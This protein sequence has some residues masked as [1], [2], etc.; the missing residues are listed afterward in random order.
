MK[1]EGEERKSKKK[2]DERKREREKK[3]EEKKDFGHTF[4]TFT[5]FSPP[6][7]SFNGF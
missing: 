1:G 5:V 4:F 7:R 2:Q 3:R 6:F